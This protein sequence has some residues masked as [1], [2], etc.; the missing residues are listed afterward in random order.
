MISAN[1]KHS[2]ILAL[3]VLVAA[4]SNKTADA[5]QAVKD[6]NY[7]RAHLDEAETAVAGCREKGPEVKG[8]ELTNCQN[9]RFALM[10]PTESV[11]TG[12]QYST[13]LGGSR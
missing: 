2:A 5:P 10:S 6:I 9:A 4:C 8:V 7:Y 13:A 1:V 3:A 11:K 12:K